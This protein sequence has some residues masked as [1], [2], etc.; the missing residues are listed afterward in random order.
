MVPSAGS[1]N[2]EE[3]TLWIAEKIEIKEKN[4]RDNRSNYLKP[5]HRKETGKNK[6]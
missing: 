5:I 6:Q 2:S 4:Y 3:N 1:I